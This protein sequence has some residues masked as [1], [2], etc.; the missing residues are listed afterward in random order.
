MRPY[1]SSFVVD[2]HQRMHTLAVR[3]SWRT[4]MCQD[5]LVVSHPWRQLAVDQQLLGFELQL[6][7]AVIDGCGCGSGQE[8]R[9]E[10]LSERHQCMWW[11]LT[12]CCITNEHLAYT[13]I[14]MESW[15]VH[16]PALYY[17][18]LYT[19]WN[20]LGFTDYLWIPPIG[21]DSPPRSK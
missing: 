2:V 7:L 13:T 6:L 5:V 16:L 9:Q 18:V 1:V 21:A 3:K 10:P 8:A 17:L 15:I 19:S 4:I 12:R 11:T 20:L 14:C